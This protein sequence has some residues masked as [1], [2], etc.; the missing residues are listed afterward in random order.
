MISQSNR[1][2]ET[3]RD[4]TPSYA[5]FRSTARGFVCYT[6]KRLKKSDRIALFFN[7][8]DFDFT[9]V[10]FFLV[11][12]HQAGEVLPLRPH[13]SHKTVQGDFGVQDLPQECVYVHSIC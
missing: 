3:I 4:K 10:T 7:L 5:T 11:L 1:N 12:L 9:E 8:S 6:K 2:K 13:R